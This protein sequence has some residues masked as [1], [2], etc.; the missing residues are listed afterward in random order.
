MQLKKIC[1]ILVILTLVINNISSAQE[2][3]TIPKYGLSASF[4]DSQFD[5]VIPFWISSTFKLSPA[6]SFISVSDAGRDYSIGFILNKYLKKSKVSP[7]IG[8]RG[9]LLIASPDQGD[10]V[11]D[12][13]IGVS[14]GGEYFIDNF[15]SFGLEA[16]LNASISDNKSTRFGN[17]GG[18]IINTSMAI[19]G[20]IYF[21]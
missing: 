7:F 11:T 5:I 2:T 14:F 13:V 6:V 4:Q 9:G 3:D 21:N 15:F 12:S 20:S 18:S 8:L 19:F 16:Q 1:F 10:S 17:P